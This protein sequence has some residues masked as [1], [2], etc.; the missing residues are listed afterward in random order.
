MRS[1]VSRA[2]GRRGRRAPRRRPP[3]RGRRRRRGGSTSQAVVAAHRVDDGRGDRQPGDG[4]RARGRRTSPTPA[5][6]RGPSRPTVTSMPPVRSSATA[7][8]TSAATASGS[9]PPAR[10]RDRVAVA[11]R[12]ERRSTA[13]H[14]VSPRGAPR[15]HAAAPVAAVSSS[16]RRGGAARLPRVGEVGAAVTA[17]ALGARLRAAATAQAHGEQVGRLQRPPPR[18]RRRRRRRR[19]P[20]PRGRRRP[21]ASASGVREHADVARHRRP[22]R[23][24]VGRR[25]AAAAAGSGPSVAAATAVGQLPGQVAPETGPGDDPLGEAVAAPAGWRRARPVQATSPTA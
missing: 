20:S 12:V 13:S 19:R 23:G 18:R 16:A 10:R 9:S 14:H 15:A 4:S 25:R 17:A 1:A 22:D 8:R 24:A 7:A 2:A 11:E 3:R 6:R 21:A 5:G